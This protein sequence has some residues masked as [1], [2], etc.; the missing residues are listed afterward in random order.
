MFFSEQIGVEDSNEAELLAIEHG[1]GKLMVE[2]NSANAIGWATTGLFFV[3]PASDVICATREKTFLSDTLGCWQMQ[4]QLF[5][6]P[7]PGVKR[8]SNFSTKYSGS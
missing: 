5:F 7:R 6:H 4:L 1:V 8:F 3:C 2:G